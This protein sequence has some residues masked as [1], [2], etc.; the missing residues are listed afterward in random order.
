MLLDPSSGSNLPGVQLTAAEGLFS[1]CVFPMCIFP[2]SFSVH[3]TIDPLNLP[4]SKSLQHGESGFGAFKAAI[5]S[6]Q[7]QPAHDS[8]GKYWVMT[9]TMIYDDA[10]LVRSTMIEINGVGKCK[11]LC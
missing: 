7:R 6:Y 11:F 5:N 1:T 8:P 10:A 3:M 2:R 9:M 4:G